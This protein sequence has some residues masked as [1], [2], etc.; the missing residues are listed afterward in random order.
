MKRKTM[1]EKRGR[2]CDV[3]GQQ[4]PS[5]GPIPWE[6]DCHRVFIGSGDEW[7]RTKTVMSCSAKCRAKRGWVE[8][9]GVAHGRS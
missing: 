2:V 5:D 9:K 1:A 3:C 7:A 8:R 6:W 4:G